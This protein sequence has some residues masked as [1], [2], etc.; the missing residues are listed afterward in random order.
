MNLLR[1]L[2]RLSL[3]VAVV[4]YT[5]AGLAVTPEEGP[6]IMRLAERGS[7]GAQVLLGG[8]YLRGEGGVARDDRRAAEW[9]EKAALQGNAYAE[10]QLGDLY[11]KGQGVPKNVALAADWR[12]EAANRGTVR[13]QRLLGKM[14]LDGNGVAKDNGKAEYWLNR[15][16]L[17]GGDAE[18]Q[19]LLA[20]MHRERQTA[21]PNPALADNLLA[22]AAAQSY[23]DA[24]ELQ[25]RIQELGY[26]IEESLHQRP[27]HLHKLAE[28]GDAVAQ[29]QLGLRLENGPFRTAVDYREAVEWFERAAASGH[30]MAM[31]SLAH[32]YEA[33]V[34]G[35][36]ADPEKARYWR[37][38]ADQAR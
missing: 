16:A 10:M 21:T 30:V 14:Y 38:K 27:P 35:V 36:A 5:A 19:Y 26:S 25:H 6:L 13:A 28:D 33:G 32:I 22:R 31:R 17:E 29:Y 2:L 11:E 4:L 9:L 15:A 24:V 23:E 1:R 12:Q 37:Q 7:A 8:M 34:E 20:L 3:G 18:A